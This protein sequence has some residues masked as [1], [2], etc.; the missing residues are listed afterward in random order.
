M[1]PPADDV[2]FRPFAIGAP[3]FGRIFV[4]ITQ[5]VLK[6]NEMPSIYFWISIA[7]SLLLGAVFYIFTKTENP[8]KCSILFS[9]ASFVISVMWIKL[10]S[11]ILVDLIGLLGIVFDID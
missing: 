3:F 9:L 10:F 8:P 7:L 5:R 1:P 2:W 4:S 11:G 6:F